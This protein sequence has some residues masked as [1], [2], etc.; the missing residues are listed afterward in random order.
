MQDGPPAVRLSAGRTILEVGFKLHQERESHQRQ[1]RDQ[2]SPEERTKR[3][4]EQYRIELERRGVCVD[5]L[6]AWLERRDME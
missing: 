2:M 6:S 1:V 5:D 3:L 4:E